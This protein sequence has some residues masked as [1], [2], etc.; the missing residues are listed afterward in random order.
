[1]AGKSPDRNW[2]TTKYKISSLLRIPES[3]QAELLKTFDGHLAEMKNHL[4]QKKTVPVEKTY[5]CFFE[6]Y[7][8]LKENREKQRLFLTPKCSKNLEKDTN[9]MSEEK[10]QILWWL[11][12]KVPSLRV[13]ENFHSE[14][15]DCPKD[16]L[17]AY[18]LVEAADPVL[19]ELSIL[20]KRLKAEKS[21]ESEKETLCN[22]LKQLAEKL[23]EVY[24]ELM[25]IIRSEDCTQGFLDLSDSRSYYRDLI[26]QYG[27][28]KNC[29]NQ[30]SLVS[31]TSAGDKDPNETVIETRNGAIG[32]TQENVEV[33]FRH[34]ATRK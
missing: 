11:V 16:R 26:K 9:R 20:E 8:K 24:E 1:M 23:D 31:S 4:A 14:F 3:E 2:K 30:T 32:S 22:Q 12:D 5:Q 33:S 28:C 19:N 13:N 27:H 7:D 29:G 6:T 25:R 34:C 17:Q 15:V 18:K 10:R 21:N